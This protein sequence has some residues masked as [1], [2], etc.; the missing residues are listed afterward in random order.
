MARK[1]KGF[2]ELLHQKQDVEQTTAQSF[3][4][5]HKKVK[6]ATGKD[7]IEDIAINPKDVAKMSD[8]L[9]EFID[10]YK[11]T[12]Y[13]LEEVECLL[14]L[15]VVAWDIA[16][17]PKEDRQ[18]AIESMLSEVASG[19]NRKSRAAL[20]TLIH[21]LIERKDCYFS[22]CQRYIAN[23]DLQPQGDSYFLSVASSLEE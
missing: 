18:E 11:G 20:Q 10:P 3:K 22:D 2:S 1:S 15:A 17:L 13:G 19:M 16:L 21:E 9:N 14:S 12:A 5:L 8:I 6:K 7:L 4:R 23:F